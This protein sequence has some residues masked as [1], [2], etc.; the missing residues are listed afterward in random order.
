MSIQ[1]YDTAVLECTEEENEMYQGTKKGDILLRGTVDGQRVN[2]NNSLVI[3]DKEVISNNVFKQ[4]DQGIISNKPSTAGTL[5]GSLAP[6]EAGYTKHQETV[7]PEDAMNLLNTIDVHKYTN[8]QMG[9]S[10]SQLE[11]IYP[12]CVHKDTDSNKHMIDYSKLVPYTLLALRMFQGMKSTGVSVM[13][14]GAKGDGITDDT[15]AFDMALEASPLVYVPAGSFV[16]GG[17]RDKSLGETGGLWLKG[18]R[19]VIMVGGTRLLRHSDFIGHEGDTTFNSCHMILCEGENNNILGNGATI[20]EDLVP[21]LTNSANKSTCINFLNCKH[22]SVEFINTIN[23]VRRVDSNVRISTNSSYI[24]IKNCRAMRGT[25]GNFFQIL[26]ANH[27][28]IVGCIAEGIQESGKMKFGDVQD[29]FRLGQNSNHNRVLDCT[30]IKTRI[31]FKETG[32]N[33]WSGCTATECIGTGFAS[34]SPSTRGTRFINCTSFA[35]K[36]F[37]FFVSQENTSISNYICWDNSLSGKQSFLYTS[38]N[39]TLK[40][41]TDGSPVD[42]VEILVKEKACRITDATV[43]SKN[44]THAGLYING[45]Y[46]TVV[47]YFC[48]TGPLEIVVDANNTLIL[49]SH[50]SSVGTSS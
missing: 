45:D 39:I 26:E 38:H 49:G 30:A 11:Q 2:V 17:T 22:S 43:S 5:Y 15:V 34:M 6:D 47:S 50:V 7:T 32:N 8:G 16:L 19:T 18:N 12:K 37:G 33:L 9:C 28:S 35:N 4:K 36:G 27:C 3:S 41:T 1:D 46:C 21:I 44:S 48:D 31:G 42:G 29:G 40:N 24:N 13:D 20:D 10:G 14:Y 25:Y 23:P